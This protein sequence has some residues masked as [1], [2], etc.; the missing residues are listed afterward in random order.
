[1]FKYNPTDG[2]LILDPSLF[3]DAVDDLTTAYEA[4]D[5]VVADDEYGDDDEDDG[6]DEAFVIGWYVH[7]D[8]LLLRRQV[9]HRVEVGQ[10][11]VDLASAYVAGRRTTSY[12]AAETIS[13][14]GVSIRHHASKYL[15]AARSSRGLSW[16][17]P[18]P[19]L[20]VAHRRPR[21]QDPQEREP[22]QQVWSWSTENRCLS[23]PYLLVDGPAFVLPQIA[24]PPPCRSSR[25]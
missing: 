22:G 24:H 17:I 23:V 9:G 7:G 4:A 15:A 6:L 20:H 2:D 11:V 13:N 14:C 19:R 18:T 21:T 3:D 5:A 25:A 8:M 10:V 1:M 16:K 12:K